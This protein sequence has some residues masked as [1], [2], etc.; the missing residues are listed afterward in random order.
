MAKDDQNYS[1]LAQAQQGLANV[2]LYGTS[3]DQYQA[4]NDA[5]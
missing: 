5:Q 1:G 3:E 4:L 2:P